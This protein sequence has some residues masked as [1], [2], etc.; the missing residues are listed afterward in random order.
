LGPID[1]LIRLGPIDGNAAQKKNGSRTTFAGT[2]AMAGPS[3][4][5]AYRMLA[6][7]LRGDEGRRLTSARIPGA[8]VF[9]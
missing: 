9:D 4:T 8:I 1:P 2:S 6:E 7:V 3:L 5:K